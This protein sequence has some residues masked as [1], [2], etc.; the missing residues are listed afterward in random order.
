MSQLDPRQ[1]KTREKLK[2]AAIQIFSKTNGNPTIKEICEEARITRPTFYNHYDSVNDL[3]E[4]LTAEILL[5]MQTALAV[6]TL[7][8][9]R[10]FK[11]NEMPKIFTKL[12]SHIEE[13]FFFYET[14]LVKRREN[15]I[16]DEI[17]NLLKNYITS[18][19]AVVEPVIPYIAPSQLI[20]NYITGAYYQSI[21]W[22]IENKRPYPAEIMYTYMIS[23]SLKGPYSNLIQHN[24]PEDGLKL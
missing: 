4:S 11:A 15:T 2:T 10:D 17:F 14:F 5:D 20:A 7:P 6:E 24:K 1:L 3:K 9:I 8:P 22:W 13:N 19:M 16:C 23:L 12:F 18:G 21:V